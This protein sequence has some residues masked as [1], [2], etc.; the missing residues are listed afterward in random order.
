MTKC[1]DAGTTGPQGMARPQDARPFARSLG[2]ST[3]RRSSWVLTTLGCAGL[4]LL[5]ACAPGASG[6][7]AGLTSGFRG[8]GKSGA[9]QVVAILE[10]EAPDRDTFV[11]HGTIPVPPGTYPRSDNKVAFSV[12]DPSGQIAPTQMEIVSRYPDAKQGADVVEV[13]AHVQR[14]PGAQPGDRIQ[15]EVIEN[16]HSGRKYKPSDRVK[17]LLHTP[18]SM[19]VVATDVFGHQYGVQ[20]YDTARGQ[21]GGTK[22]P[23]RGGEVAKT[24]R[25]YGIM[26]PF[27]AP[28]GAPDGAL[29]HLFGVHAYMTSFKG[30]D[31]LQVSLRVHNG[32]SG[33][34]KST[35]ADNPLGKVNF[36]KL[37]LWVPQGWEVH[38]P[39]T[40]PGTGVA[41]N[42]NSWR[43]HP[44]VAPRTDGKMHVMPAQ[45]QMERRF[46]IAPVGEDI[47][48]QSIAREEGQAFCRPGF[49][50]KGGELYSWWNRQTA[51]YF[52]QAHRLPELPHLGEANIR[53]K[54]KGEYNA[55]RNQLATGNTGNFPVSNPQYGWAKP[56]GSAYG[57][58][59]GGSEIFIFDGIPTAFAASLDGY[60][61]RQIAHRMY[62]DRQPDTLFNKDGEPT[63]LS[64]WIVKGSI[65]YFPALFFQ[66]LLAGGG[67]PFGLG[68]SASFQRDYVASK[69]LEAGYG[70]TLEG[71]KPVDFQHYTRYTRNAKVL[72]WLGNDPMAKDDIMMR[73]ELFRMSYNLYPNNAGGGSIV[74]GMLADQKAI[75]WH[76]GTGMTFGRGEAWGLDVS[77]AAYRIADDTWRTEALPWFEDIADLVA[78]GQSSCNGFIQALVMPKMLNGQYHVRQSIEQSI[79][80]NAL[81][82]LNKSV[83]EGRDTGRFH[84]TAYVL[85]QSLYSMIGPMAWNPKYNG[86]WSYLAVGPKDKVSGTYCGS[87]PSGGG[88]NGP[89]LFQIWSSFAYGYEL[90]GDPQFLDRAEEAL[91]GDLH[92]FLHSSGYGNLENRAALLALAQ[93]IY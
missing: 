46:V 71:F 9:S 75:A 1:W 63:R 41:Y 66:T 5:G 47:R 86:P 14:P 74:S 76:P 54:H 39:N 81:M 69:G 28:V 21:I 43:V 38:Q 42:Q 32:H 30:E 15:Y 36:A 73:T 77:N 89:D 58:M 31:S 40:D 84:Q 37:E 78:S 48:A 34:D 88:A 29:D 51:R 72:T 90:T 11:V 22:K 13:L 50:P 59:T 18:G 33:L 27:G 19:L 82:G 23:F 87:I 55:L 17:K 25:T 26:S 16:P 35:P 83:F 45:A 53:A 70:P 56:W 92:T 20:L 85:E 52:P 8:G 68:H 24:M 91:G 6:G 2:G 65:E 64:Q 4:A 3:E 10:T 60:R 80:E 79:T 62:T 12:V 67:D 49:A 57:G 61:H 93:D 7:S 44:I